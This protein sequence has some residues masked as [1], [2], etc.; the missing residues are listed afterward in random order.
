MTATRTAS[1]GPTDR[2]S[3]PVSR[4]GAPRARPAA[5]ELVRK[6]LRGIGFILLLTIDLEWFGLN[7]RSRVESRRV[8][9]GRDDLRLR[10]GPSVWIARHSGRD[11]AAPALGIPRHSAARR[12]LTGRAPARQTPGGLA[13]LLRTP[14]I[15][16]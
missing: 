2:G 4:R 15:S 11:R 13:N 5:I 12:E 3:A 9:P 7:R 8:R 1:L 16:G 10:R 14:E 6:L